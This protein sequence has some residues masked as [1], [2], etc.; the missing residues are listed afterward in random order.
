[1]A[2]YGSDGRSEASIEKK[3]GKNHAMQSGWALSFRSGKVVSRLLELRADPNLQN[4]DNLTPIQM[5]MRM[6]ADSVVG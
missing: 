4:R 1:M 3:S 5:H 2:M 6:I